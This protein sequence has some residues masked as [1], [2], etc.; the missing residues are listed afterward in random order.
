MLFLLNTRRSWSNIIN[1]KNKKIDG[2][3]RRFVSLFFLLFIEDNK[4]LI[5]IFE[6]I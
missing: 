3:D 5:I 6:M 4:K 2:W 1:N